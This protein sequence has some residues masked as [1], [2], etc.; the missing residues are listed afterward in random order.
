MKTIIRDVSN[1]K[2][3][4]FKSFWIYALFLGLTSLF[5]YPIFFGKVFFPGDL[6]YQLPPW[7]LNN[8]K[9]LKDILPINN[10]LLG[11]PVTAFY[12]WYTF[13]SSAIRDGF[14]PLWNPLVMGGAPFLANWQSGALSLQNLIF[15]FINSP[16]ALNINIFLRLFLSL[17]FTYLFLRKI[18]LSK[19][20]SVFGSL[21]YTF[22]AFFI[23]WLNWPQTRVAVWLPLILFSAE[24]LFEKTTVR[25]AA[26]VAA[27]IGGAILAGHPGT[28]VQVLFIFVF[29]SA[30]KLFSQKEERLNK[31]L[32]LSASLTLGL[33]LGAVLILPGFEMMQNSFQYA[34]RGS[35]NYLDF[36]L[37]FGNIG[38]LFFPKFYGH[39]KDGIYL[40]PANFNEVSL[41]VGLLPL[42][43]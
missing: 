26:F 38:L 7:S 35:T 25:R 8:A 39:L 33:G 19:E 42:F 13:L 10:P 28:L 1:E 40:G 4:R 31:A 3:K 43:F 16:L 17:S 2:T 15:Y 18:K 27:A 36:S 41:Y 14:F 32:Y 20:A 37:S 11:D 6:L 29:Y 5:L 21:A 9:V 24:H 22:S 34:Q 30:Y 12:P 23:V